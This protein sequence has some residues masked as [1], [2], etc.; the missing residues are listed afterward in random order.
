LRTLPYV[1]AWYE[2]YHNDG[3]VIVGVHTPEFGFSGQQKNVASAAQRLGVVWPV[4]LDTNQEIWKR[5]AN[6]AWPQEYL[7]DQ[8]GKLVEE[9]SGEGQ[10]QETETKIQSL[11][12]AANPRLTLPPVMALLPQDNYTK[13][14]AVCYMDTPEILLERT[15]I[16]NADKSVNPRKDAAY[17]D[18]GSKYADGSIYLQGTWHMTEQAAVTA[19]APGYLVLPYHAI[20][21]VGVMAPPSAAPVRVD[22]TQDN[23]PIPKDDAGTDIHYDANGASF[24][25]VDSSRAYELLMNAKMAFHNLRLTPQAAGV[26]VYSFAFESCEIPK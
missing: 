14:G 22:V 19:G 2:R 4:V 26:G 5:Y 24:V 8:S 13:P 25:T 18:P 21:V 16:A 6:S 3:L 15:K 10:Y 9:T 20:Q 1:R 23:A 12:K 17:T 11:L 7:F